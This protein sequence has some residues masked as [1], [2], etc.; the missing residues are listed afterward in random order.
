MAETF[1]YLWPELGQGSKQLPVHLRS[2]AGG[3]GP[4]R[5]HGVQGRETGGDQDRGAQGQQLQDHLT[6]G[7]HGGARHHH[8]DLLEPGVN[9]LCEY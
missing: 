5:E 4:A 2:E 1:T 9:I 3:G 8:Q 6:T 7:L